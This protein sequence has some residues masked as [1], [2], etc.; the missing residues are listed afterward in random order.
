MTRWWTLRVTLDASLPPVGPSYR[1]SFRSL[2]H[3]RRLWFARRFRSLNTRRGG[4]RC[5][6]DAGGIVAS[7]PPPAKRLL[8]DH[9]TQPPPSLG[10][11][12]LARAESSN[13]HAQQ[14]DR[15]CWV[16][17]RSP[18]LFRWRSTATERDSVLGDAYRLHTFLLWSRLANC[19]EDHFW[20]RVVL[21]CLTYS[22]FAHLPAQ[23]GRWRL[24]PQRRA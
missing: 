18:A 16:S 8:R 22:E 13:P 2:P 3:F 4:D 23:L 9:P 7:P 19:F 21:P 20:R 11:S 15:A 12:L 14:F 17:L 1:L 24:G 6:A 10:G 5:D